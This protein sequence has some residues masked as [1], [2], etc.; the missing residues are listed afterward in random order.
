MPKS[1]K[2]P[3]RKPSKSKKSKSK[4]KPK[5]TASKR[6]KA[7]RIAPKASKAKQ[8]KPRPK[9]KASKEKPKSKRKASEVDGTIAT[10][11]PPSS[12]VLDP[13][14]PGIGCTI[15]REY[16]GESIAVEQTAAGFVIVSPKS[17][18]DGVTYRGLSGVTKAF[19]G[20]ET[21][22]FAFFGLN[23]KPEAVAAE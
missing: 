1:S 6:I 4:P 7:K 11:R 12:R 20:C 16:K 8:T 10:L 18:I 21:N 14:L 13:R 19:T 22:G 9:S 3:K 23:P 17:K 5:R 2:S 15:S